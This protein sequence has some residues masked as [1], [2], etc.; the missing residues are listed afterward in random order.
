M[1]F[2]RFHYD[3]S[4][5]NKQ[6]QQMTDPG[7]HTLSNPISNEDKMNYFEDP[8]IRMQKFD[9]MGVKNYTTLERNLQGG[10]IKNFSNMKYNNNPS[11]TM[12]TEQTR[13]TN[14]AWNLRDL[15]QTDREIKRENI[16]YK[17]PFENNVSTRIYEK[18]NYK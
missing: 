9:I 10:N 13:T 14:P 6:H 11:K 3:S 2:T 17:I 4:R 18:N 15:E 7:K 1:S 5:F 16:P 8:T 12:F